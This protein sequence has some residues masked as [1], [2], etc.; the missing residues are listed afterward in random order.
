MIA[1][2]ARAADE[3][4]IKWMVTGAHLPIIAES[5]HWL[6]RGQ[7][8]NSSSSVRKFRHYYDVVRDDSLAD[9]DNLL[10]PGVIAAGSQLREI[11]TTAGF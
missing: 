9:T 8:M 6:C 5:Q 3:L 11:C 7:A 10:P 2:V 4:D 1:A